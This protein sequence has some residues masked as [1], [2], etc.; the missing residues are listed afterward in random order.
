MALMALLLLLLLLLNTNAPTG[1]PLLLVLKRRYCYYN[2]V[3]LV[4]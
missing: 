2:A 4:H 3:L 1:I